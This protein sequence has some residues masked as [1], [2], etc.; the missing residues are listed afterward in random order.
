MLAHNWRS[1]QGSVPL[2]QGCQGNTTQIGDFQH[3][4]PLQQCLVIANQ[5]HQGIRSVARHAIGSLGNGKGNAGFF[6]DGVSFRWLQG[7]MCCERS[8]FL[9]IKFRVQPD[10]LPGNWLK[11]GLRGAIAQKLHL[12]QHD[13]GQKTFTQTGKLLPIS[14]VPSYQRT[15]VKQEDKRRQSNHEILNFGFWILDFER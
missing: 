8:R 1:A 11:V 7:R 15:D 13:L 4:H 6:T 3:L 9:P 10:E 5:H 2:H 12:L 14:R